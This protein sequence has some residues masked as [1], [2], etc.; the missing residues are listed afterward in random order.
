MWR[1]EANEDRARRLVRTRLHGF[2]ATK[3][4]I[5]KEDLESEYM[6]SEFLSVLFSV[7]LRVH[8]LILYSQ[9][10]APERSD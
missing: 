8:H 2:R 6:H 3:A 4:A 5:M 9:Y 10:L 7:N 1:R